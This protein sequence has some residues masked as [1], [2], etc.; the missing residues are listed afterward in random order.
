MAKRILRLMTELSSRKSISRIMGHF[1]HS[2]ISR[3]VIP[4][5]IRNYQIPVSEA[6]K[7][8]DEYHSL[9][10][11]FTRRLKPGMRPIDSQEHSLSSPVDARITAMGTISSGTILNVKGQNYT[12]EEILH[13]SPHLELY[14]HGYVF[15]LYLSPTDYHRIHSPVTGVK[16]ESE[17]IKGRVYPVND[18]G[19]THMPYVLCRNERLITYIQHSLGEVAVVK[20]GAMNVSSI[21]YTDESVNKWNKGD[22]L[23]YFE[24]GSTVVLLIEN[25]TFTPREDLKPGDSVRMGQS[26]GELHSSKQ[27]G[28]I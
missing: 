22:D 23:A 16:R 1:S 21:Q 5:F 4:M 20:V 28:N 10:A 17:H 3:Y 19:M 24:F 27:K 15:V 26:L 11:F 18:F 8:I 14:K 12:V 9:N 25:G 7:N 6:E 13:H 2:R